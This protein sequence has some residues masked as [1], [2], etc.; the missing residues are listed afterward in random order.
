MTIKELLEKYRYKQSY[1]FKTE[2]EI[3]AFE[4]GFSEC[5]E[6]LLSSVESLE[7]ILD[8]SGLKRFSSESINIGYRAVASIVLTEIREKMK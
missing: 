5:Q 1:Q 2:K 3:I 4:K 8:D 7:V 6:L